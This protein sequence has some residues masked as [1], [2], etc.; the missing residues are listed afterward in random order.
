MLNKS[1]V[2]P[3]VLTHMECADLERYLDTHACT[4]QF[5]AIAVRMID[6]SRSRWEWKCGRTATETMRRARQRRP[7]A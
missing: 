5:R 6:S 4:Q 2:G 1:T 7:R 3:P